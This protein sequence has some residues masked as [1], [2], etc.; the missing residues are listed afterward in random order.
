[1]SHSENYGIRST[2]KS[3]GN[4]RQ[5]RNNRICIFLS[6]IVLFSILV[7]PVYAAIPVADFTSNVTKGISPLAVGFTDTSSNLPDCWN[8]SFGDG[9]W[10]NTTDVAQKNPSYTYTT[11]GWYSVTLIANNTEGSNQMVKTQYINIASNGMTNSTNIPGVSMTPAPSSTLE[12]R[13]NKSTLLLNRATITVSGNQAI[14][15][16]PSP[17][18]SSSVFDY[19]TLTDIAGNITGDAIRSIQLNTTPFISNLA[20]FGPTTV[21]MSL[22]LSQYSLGNTITVLMSDAPSSSDAAAFSAAAGSIRPLQILGYEID[23]DTSASPAQYPNLDYADIY[24]TVPLSW[25]ATYGTDNIRLFR[26]HDSPYSVSV[27]DASLNSTTAT[28]ATYWATSPYPSF[29]RFSPGAISPASTPTPT[30]TSSPTIFIGN[31]GGGD[32]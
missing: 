19:F 15:T 22:N 5:E 30:P 27:L 6:F 1:M 3:S 16:N 9:T 12:P 21:F 13:L 4:F 11:K 10:F 31:D 17:F 2:D 24:F 25:T 18:F 28:T 7:A 8:W 14:V 26:I 32:L 20:G 23:I 29:S